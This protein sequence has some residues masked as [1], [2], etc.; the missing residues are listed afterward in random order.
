MSRSVPTVEARRPTSTIEI[1]FGI[2]PRAS[3]TAKARPATISEKY[4]AGPKI[5]ASL[6]SGTARAAT[7]SV[8][9]E[10]A[11]NE[12]MAAMPSAAPARPCFA[13]WW[14]SSVVTTA[15]TSPGMLTRMAVVEPPYCAP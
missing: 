14:P 5:I 15:V 4:S 2:E 10:P 9:N 1:A 7:T 13:I 3:T 11:K 6:V 8:A 12:P